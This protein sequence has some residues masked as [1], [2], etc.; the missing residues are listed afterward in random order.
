MKFGTI[1]KIKFETIDGAYSRV[2]DRENFDSQITLTDYEA[3]LVVS[4]FG[5]PNIYIG[6]VGS[7][8]GRSAKQ[9]RLFPDGQVIDLNIIYPKPN[10]SELRLYISSR[11]GFKPDAGYI[12]FIFKKDDDL[13][14]GAMSEI[15]WRNS[16]SEAKQDESDDDYQQ[17]VNE[18][19]NIRITKLKERDIYA[20]DRNVAL[21]RLKLSGFTCEYDST[22][23][24]FISRFTRKSYLEVHHLIPMGL[25]GEF[26]KSLDTMS[27]VFCLCPYCHRAVHHAEE[28]LAREILN[29]LADKRPVLDEFSLS[30]PELFSLYAVEE[31]D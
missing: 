25:Q 24:L 18:S 23:N 9:F 4:H 5:K 19:D 1:Q 2:T 6:N 20:R 7:S 10:K 17:T 8:G 31:I 22:H 28:P 14:I 3:H 21:E 13:W 12:W 26:S 16:S 11:A 27:N 30:I 29:K 15:S